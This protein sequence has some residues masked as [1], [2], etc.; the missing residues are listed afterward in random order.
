MRLDWSRLRIIALLLLLSSVVDLIW[1]LAGD[2]DG[3]RVRLGMAGAV[4]VVLLWASAG[5]TAPRAA[6]R[7]VAGVVLISIV[8]VAAI[9]IYLAPYDSLF[10]WLGLGSGPR[11]IYEY[12]D[13]TGVSVAVSWDL[14]LL[15]PI[16]AAAV[17][18]LCRTVRLRP[19]PRRVDLRL[20]LVA[21]PFLG[22][23]GSSLAEGAQVAALIA[24]ISGGWLILALRALGT[25]NVGAST[26]PA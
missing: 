17:G 3:Q 5:R 18:P 6:A 2:L 10:G 7:S 11:R 23:A 9:F 22:L 26:R 21:L 8:P 16:L 19:A 25:T 15:S 1:W 12:D 13:V 24:L 20:I 14:A 4:A